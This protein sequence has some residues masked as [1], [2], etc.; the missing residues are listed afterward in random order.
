MLP[1]IVTEAASKKADEVFDVKDNFRGVKPQ[2][3][4]LEILHAEQAF[5][6]KGSSEQPVSSFRGIIV[7]HYTGRTYFSR[8]MSAGQ[9]DRPACSSDNGTFGKP[10]DIARDGSDSCP[11]P[12]NQRSTNTQRYGHPLPCAVCPMNQ[13]GSDLKG[14]RGKACSEK[15]YFFVLPVDPEL[16]SLKPYRLIA[17]PTSLKDINTFFSYLVG[18]NVPHQVVITTFKL[19]KGPDRGDL[20]YSE[21]ILEADL[22][23]KLPRDDQLTLKAIID[24][25]K[26]GFT[27]MDEP[28]V[29]EDSSQAPTPGDTPRSEDPVDNF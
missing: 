12:A 25:Y 2:L 15:H 29:V 1:A 17:P 14:G 9:K 4:E 20:D 23:K 8:V 10:I 26:A 16:A 3:P 13:W 11:I 19:R 18:K 24:T 21:L 6:V 7:Y 22:T 28:K 5:R 27:S